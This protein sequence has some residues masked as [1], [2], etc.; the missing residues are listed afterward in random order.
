MCVLPMPMMLVTRAG[1]QAAGAR[2]RG[3]GGRLRH[4]ADHPGIRG[5]GQLRNWAVREKIVLKRRLRKAA[6]PSIARQFLP[7]HAP[8]GVI[9]RAMPTDQ[10]IWPLHVLEVRC[11]SL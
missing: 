9:L 10:L 3:E 7:L 2:F 5:A 11:L 8:R 4:A 6:G 1:A